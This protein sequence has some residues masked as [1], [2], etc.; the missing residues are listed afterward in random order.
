M[1]TIDPYGGCE[2]DWP[3]SVLNAASQ[4]ATL[5][6]LTPPALRPTPQVNQIV[7]PDLAHYEICGPDTLACTAA[8]CGHVGSAV[9][10]LHE[11]LADFRA[12]RWSDGSRWDPNRGSNLPQLGAL[13]ERRG[14]PV[15]RLY[16]P[17][18]DVAASLAQQ[19]RVGIT[20]LNTAYGSGALWNSLHPQAGGRVGHWEAIGAVN[21]AHAED[22][23]AD[24]AALLACMRLGTEALRQALIERW[25]E[26][27]PAIDSFAQNMAAHPDQVLAITTTMLA[28]A[29]NDPGYMPTRMAK[30][31]AAARAAGWTI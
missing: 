1:L 21:A 20:A 30:L 23:M 11:L 25:P 16:G 3:Q 10:T 9:D 24:P 22:P 26:D 14:W 6:F 31:E 12:Q 15:E 5:A 13:A 19:G 8:A 4:G 17:A 7:F 29:S 2:E 28:I 18:G 27:L